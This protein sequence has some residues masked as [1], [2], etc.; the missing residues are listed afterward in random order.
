MQVNEM[1]VIE[2]PEIKDKDAVDNPVFSEV[3]FQENAE[4]FMFFDNNTGDL[5]IIN[6][7]YII[8][9]DP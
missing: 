6:S 4:S 5:N 7:T 2:L 1:L 9:I 3:R 8:L